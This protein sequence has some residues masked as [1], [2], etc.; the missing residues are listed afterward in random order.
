M[1]DNKV[2]IKDNKVSINQKAF[3]EFI[4]LFRKIKK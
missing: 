3:I 1:I 2:I 4:K